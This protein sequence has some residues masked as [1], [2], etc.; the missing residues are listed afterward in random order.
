MA[1]ISGLIVSKSRPIPFIVEP[2]V[3]ELTASERHAAQEWIAAIKPE[4]PVQVVAGTYGIWAYK[5]INPDSPQ[6]KLL[7]MGLKA[8]PPLI[9]ALQDKTVS[10][11]KR[12]WILSL[13]F[14][15]TGENDPRRLRY[16]DALG[17]YKYI[18]GSWRAWGNRPGERPQGGMG[19][20][21][22]GSNYWF[23]TTTHIDLQKQQELTK[24]W[25]QWLQTMQVR[26][27]AGGN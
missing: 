6:G 8:A 9:A 13:L 15:L 1:E 12:A 19:L 11:E 27:V 26:E 16:E 24:K 22:E 23:W 17:S 21:G 5:F 25:V 10:R 18:E 3:I 2:T 14:G 4:Q 20:G 7:S